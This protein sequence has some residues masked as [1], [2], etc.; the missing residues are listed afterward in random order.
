MKKIIIGICLVLAVVSVSKS[1]S[2]EPS[3]KFGEFLING[4]VEHKAPDAF[5][6][7]VVPETEASDID[8]QEL[9]PNDCSRGIDEA[10]Q[11]SCS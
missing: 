2:F 5:D 3:A 1:M 8:G 10:N 7:Y 11:E 4:S 6:Y 9:D